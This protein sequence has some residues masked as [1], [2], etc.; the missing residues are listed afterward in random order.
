ML[1]TITSTA[2]IETI[3]PAKA[4]EYLRRNVQN[5][6][7]VERRID[8]YAQMMAAGKW[9]LNGEAVQFDI[10]GALL[11]G[12]HRLKACIKAGVS[13]TTYV[14]RGLAK[15]VMPTLD[16]GKARSAGNALAILGGKNTFAHAAGIVWILKYRRE[17]MLYGNTTFPHQEIVDFW[18]DNR[19]RLDESSTF[20]G[21]AR[22]TL[23]L[24]MGVG[25]HFLFAEFDSL[26]AAR[27]F[28]D[29]GVGAEL[30]KNDGVLLLRERLTQ[31]KT[32]KT[33]LPPVER[34]ALVVRAWNHRRQ[35]IQ[36]KIL[37]GTYGTGSAR[38][39]PEIV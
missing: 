28:E 31:D 35:G 9:Q 13:F 1:Q 25:F 15:E 8:L 38:V 2:M 26:M 17:Q 20:A 30:G 18:E 11:N 34:A 24:G 6:T 22:N 32:A 10:N 3:T 36:T 37:R 27:F 23:S 14:I 21:R 29:L 12:Q 33:R 19:L 5:R 4:Q 39:F 7:F 16:T